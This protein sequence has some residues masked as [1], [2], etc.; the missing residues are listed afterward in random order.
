MTIVRACLCPFTKIQNNNIQAWQLVSVAPHLRGRGARV[1]ASSGLLYCTARFCLKKKKEEDG[2]EVKEKKK[3]RKQ[4][5]TQ[6]VMQHR[7]EV[8][9]VMAV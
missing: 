4:K 1:T 8:A 9:V 2:K 3:G 7:V 5:S 6:T